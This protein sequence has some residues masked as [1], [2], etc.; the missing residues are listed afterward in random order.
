MGLGKG[1]EMSGQ[2]KAGKEG[3]K[4]AKE[5]GMALLQQAGQVTRAG[6]F[7]LDKITDV[8]GDTL[9]RQRAQFASAGVRIGTGT[10][11][12]VGEETSSEFEQ[13]K[14]AVGERYA[15]QADYLR[16][17]ALQEIKY[18]K[19]LRKA[20]RLSLLTGGVQLFGSLMNL[21]GGGGQGGNLWAGTNTSSSLTTPFGG[22]IV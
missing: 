1:F 2:Y 21:G 9:A 7:E 4:A 14:F 12:V 13:K 16:S 8:Q 17:Q 19:K 5:R 11:Q 22:A 3:Y 10:P 20:G 6:L 15:S 18:G